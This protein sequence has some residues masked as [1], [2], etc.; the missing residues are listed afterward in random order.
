MRKQWRTIVILSFLIGLLCVQRAMAALP[1]TIQSESAL[2]MEVSSGEILVD[3]NSKKPLPPA[4]ITKMMVMLL[5]MEAVENGQINLADKVVASPEA[6]RMGG[7]Q[8]WLEPGE[9][10]TVEELMKA[11]GVVSAND[12]SVALA[13]YLSGSHEEFVK[14]MNKRAAELGLENTKYVNATGLSPDGGGPGNMTSAYDQA[15]LGRELLK[16]PTVLKWTGTWID[17]LRGGESFLRNTNNLVR[18][19]EGCDGLK[20]GYTTEAGY[21]LVATA[22]RN[23]VRLLAVVMKAP[24]SA[25]RN[26]EITKLF[27]Y[28][29]SQYKALKVLSKGQVLGKTKVMKG[30]VNEV[31]L[32]VP[33]DLLVV[34]KKDVQSTPEV[35][36]Q[37]PP[38]VKA[39]LTEGQPVGRIIVQIDGE[40]KVT[41]DL[42]VDQAVEESGFFRFLWQ[43]GKSMIEGFFR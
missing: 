34:L 29:F 35:L 12:A 24:T 20:T 15:I 3:K 33:E 16:H 13:E 2:L 14:L 6:C 39:P 11:I 7:S 1:F 23:G 38:K 43:I 40:T 27:N 18:F 22:R 37:I 31:N 41:A 10:M 17:S 28:G 4:S 5:V 21:C 26:N 25:V 9:E 36:V 32:V 19:Y 30:N 8:I 42:V